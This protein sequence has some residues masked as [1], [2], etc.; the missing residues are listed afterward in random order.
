MFV[1]QCSTTQSA[2]IIKNYTTQYF[3]LR[4]RVQLN[5]AHPGALKRKQYKSEHSQHNTHFGELQQYNTIK[6][7]RR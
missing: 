7:D 2:S 4:A 1:F 3:T 5:N 6:Y